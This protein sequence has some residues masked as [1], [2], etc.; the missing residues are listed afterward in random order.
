MDIDHGLSRLRVLGTGLRGRCGSCATAQRA[1]D[2][3]SRRLTEHVDEDIFVISGPELHGWVVVPRPHVSGLEELSIPHRASLL[4]A[5]RRA[6]R[7][8]RNRN[9]WSTPTIVVRSDLPASEGHVCFQVLPGP[10][11]PQ[12]IQERGSAEDPYQ[13][14]L[15]VLESR[16]SPSQGLYEQQLNNKTRLTAARHNGETTNPTE[17]RNLSNK[18]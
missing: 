16:R 18:W 8:V 14:M 5:L 3:S 13:R 9:P 12:W 10:R 15:A 17:L 4:A 6:T 11:T 7:S 2:P 1:A